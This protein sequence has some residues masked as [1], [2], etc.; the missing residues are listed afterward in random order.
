[1]TPRSIIL[2]ILTQED[3]NFLLSNRVPRRLLT[4][5]A[6]WLSRLE[7]P[8]IVAIGLFLWGLSTELELEDARPG[9]FRTLREVFTRELREGARVVDADPSVLAS[10]CDAVVGASGTV[11]DG[12]LLQIK[13][14][15]YRLQDLLGGTGLHEGYRDCRYVTLRL[16]SG[17]YHR[18]HAPHDCRV[19]QVNF[20]AG[21]TWNVNPAALRRL[22]SLYCR[23]ERAVIQCELATGQMVTM[24]PV[25]AI[26]VAT[27]RLHCLP[28]PLHLRYRG[29]HLFH[30][31]TTLRKGQE[32]GWFELGSTIVVL[33]PA[34]S[35]FAPTVTEGGRIRM[36]EALLRLPRQD[37]P[38]SA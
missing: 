7:H 18:F 2:R 27:L 37:Q 17:M 6:G 4:L 11:A 22:E 13:G 14:S 35:T 23:N 36:G 29:P 28:A 19:R 3:L 20:I 8:W 34:G 5:L 1:M 32:M 30:C 25:A 21:D 24:V 15:A 33:A 16:K 26:L 12:M 38:R 31:D 9:R 10:P